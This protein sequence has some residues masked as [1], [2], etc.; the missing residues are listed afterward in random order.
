[1]EYQGIGFIDAVKEYLAIV[2]PACRCRKAGASFRD[3]TGP[4]TR[5]DRRHGPRRQYY[6]DQLKAAPRAIEYCRNA[7]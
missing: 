1:M 3:E 7:G 5:P 6:K 2:A 4:D